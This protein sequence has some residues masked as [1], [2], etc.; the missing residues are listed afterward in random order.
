MPLLETTSSF[1]PN[2]FESKLLPPE[3]KPLETSML[4]RAKELFT[5]SDPKVIAQHLLSVDCKVG[6]E[7][8]P[9]AWQGV[10][11][12]PRS[13]LPCDLFAHRTMEMMT[14]VWDLLKGWEPRL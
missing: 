4:K 12:G 3:N 8:F 10:L 11:S 13:A 2:D 5:N 14:W 9:D 7:G 6:A 1:K